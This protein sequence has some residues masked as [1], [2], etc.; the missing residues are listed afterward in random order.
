EFLRR[1]RDV[2]NLLHTIWV[3][4][5]VDWSACP[6]SAEDREL[7][8][9]TWRGSGYEGELPRQVVEA[10]AKVVH[11]IADHYA[12]THGCN[13]VN[14]QAPDVKSVLRL[15]I[16]DATVGVV[17][18]KLSDFDLKRLYVFT[19]PSELGFAAIKRGRHGI[20]FGEFSERGK[21]KPTA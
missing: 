5:L 9:L 8:A 7:C 20:R 10:R 18:Q 4:S 19:C 11:D 13:V 17:A 21:G 12:E 15:R 1:T 16:T 14:F 3:K 6:L 2:P